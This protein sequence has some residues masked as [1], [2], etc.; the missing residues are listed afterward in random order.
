MLHAMS[1]HSP[2]ADWNR[3]RLLEGL[4]PLQ[5]G[6]ELLVINEQ[7]ARSHGTR[8]AVAEP[9]PGAVSSR[10]ST[11]WSCGSASNGQGS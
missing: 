4:E 3:Q 11:P 10:T 5:K 2:A 7:D 1:E 9:A 8:R 6:D